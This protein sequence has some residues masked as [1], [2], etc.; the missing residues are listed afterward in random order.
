M[1]GLIER[2]Y[3]TLHA[4][5]PE[6][7]IRGSVFTSPAHVLPR[8]LYLAIPELQIGPQVFYCHGICDKDRVSRHSGERGLTKLGQRRFRRHGS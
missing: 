1:T 2:E 3:P 7:R 6:L 5:V 4:T 8:P